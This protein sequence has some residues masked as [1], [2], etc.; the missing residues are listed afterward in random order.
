MSTAVPP[1]T[2]PL[3]ARAVQ[4]MVC[5]VLVGF[6]AVS[7]SQSSVPAPQ[8]FSTTSVWSGSARPPA[9]LPPSSRLS[10]WSS[11]GVAS[12]ASRSTQARYVVVPAPAVEPP[13][14][15]P[16]VNVQ[17]PSWPV[18]HVKSGVCG[19]F[20][21]SGSLAPV[22][23]TSTFAPEAVWLSPLR[24]VQ[25][26]WCDVPVGLV[27][28]SGVQSRRPGP[29]RFSTTSVSSL[30]FCSRVSF[31]SGLP[32][33]IHARYTV[34]P[35][36]L[37]LPACVTVHE[38]SCPVVQVKSGLFCESPE[39]GSFA[40]VASTSTLRPASGCELASRAVHVIWCVVPVGFEACSGEQSRPGPAHVFVTTSVS[41]WSSSAGPSL[42]SPSKVPS[43][44]SSA[45]AR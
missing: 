4:V 1:T 15:P 16:C 19:L 42:A 10:A 12:F 36:L 17:V 21:P 7:G 39:S 32:G 5:A 38:P 9:P 29:Q 44:S 45:H 24:T 20:E 41:S 3:D 25:V 31:W 37:V 40:P 6:C 2:L 33:P 28:V 34:V 43:P 11:S 22:A 27:S 30:S 35:V 26:T 18:V 23:S 14:G 8:T 13:P